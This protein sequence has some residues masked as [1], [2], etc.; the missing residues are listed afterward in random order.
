M[1]RR[2]KQ[3]MVPGRASVDR[4]IRPRGKE[5][6]TSGRWRSSEAEVHG[7]S[8]ALVVSTE[9]I[10]QNVYQ[11]DD[12]SMI[13]INCVFRVGGAAILLSNRPS[14]RSTAKY[15][16]VHTVHTHTTGSD[17]SYN[18]IF[19]ME[20]S[21][22]C[23]GVNITRDLLAVANTTIEAN[24]SA[25]GHLILPPWEK[26]RY[27]MN[28]LIR[29]FNLAKI[30]PYIPDFNTAIDHVCSHVGGKPVLDAL[31]KSLRLSEASSSSIWYELAYTEAKGRMKRGDRVWQIAF[32][33]G[34]KCSSVIWRAIK[35]VA[36]HEE[37][38]PWANEIDAYP[39]DL[40]NE[41]PIPYH[42]ELSE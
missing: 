36:G 14:D 35:T 31:Q 21:A 13:L 27:T 30:K 18:C 24:I 1:E 40:I 33:S 22:G 9:N 41:G 28:F 6:G 5:R 11:G 3:L 39:V 12:H 19:R 32:G 17:R 38:N 25:L 4:I 8:H 16:L 26:L 2:R 42:F 20:D 23:I 10:T 29:F 7:D 37:K 34:F 15:E